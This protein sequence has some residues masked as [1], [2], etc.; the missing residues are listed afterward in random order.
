MNIKNDFCMSFHA[1]QLGDKI[2]LMKNDNIG[3][4]TSVAILIRVSM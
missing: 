3:T 1:L 2:L 4:Y